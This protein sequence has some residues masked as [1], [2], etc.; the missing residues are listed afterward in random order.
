MSLFI[1]YGGKYFVAESKRH[2][3]GLLKT[4]LD[5]DLNDDDDVLI[6]TVMPIACTKEEVG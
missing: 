5:N 2:A 1:I 4:I 3:I 6:S